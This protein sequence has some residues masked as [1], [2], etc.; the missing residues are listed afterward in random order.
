M[1]FIRFTT[2]KYYILFTI[3][4]SLNREIISPY[5]CYI[6]NGLIYIVLISPFSCQPFS[7]LECTKI[8]TYLLYNI[9]SIPLNKYISL[10]RLITV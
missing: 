2:F 7:Y 5:S 1:S 3:S 9:H 6:K 4:I 10:A 8:N